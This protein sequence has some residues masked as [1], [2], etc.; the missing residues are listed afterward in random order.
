MK[1]CGSFRGVW[2]V[3]RF[4]PW[5]YAVAALLLAA[6]VWLRPWEWAPGLGGWMV[7]GSYGLAAWWVLGS[8]VV[9]HWVYDRS[10]WRR[11]GWL[12]GLAGSRSMK[13]LLNVHAG[14]DETSE[15]LRTWFPG[16][17]IETLSLFDHERLSERSIHRAAAYRPSPQEEWRGSPEAWPA[18]GGCY[19]AV[20]F[21]LSAHEFRRHEE[22]VGLLC[23]AR[24]R[25]APKPD[26]II[27]LAEHARDTANFFAFGPGFLHF[28]SAGAWRAAW[29][30]AGLE[31]TEALRVTPFLRVWVLKPVPA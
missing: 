4:N 19:D 5:F 25:L 17:K 9:S 21:L 23:R 12:R 10:D 27:V 16:A 31:M 6:G 22:R 11:G 14:F 29:E 18:P 30:E 7:L 8:L 24:E 3:V 20:L 2:Q 28:H 13:H 26:A 1:T 15:R